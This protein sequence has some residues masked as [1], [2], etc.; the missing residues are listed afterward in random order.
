MLT[1]QLH[2]CYFVNHFE[3]L[4]MLNCCIHNE[5][6]TLIEVE[7]H[8]ENQDLKANV[9]GSFSAQRSALGGAKVAL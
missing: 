8:K 4:K 3:F 6:M 7:L 2:R 5:I 9:S 1:A